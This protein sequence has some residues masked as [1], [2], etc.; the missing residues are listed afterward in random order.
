MED[1]VLGHKSISR[2]D[3]VENR[4]VIEPDK[5]VENAGQELLCLLDTLDRYT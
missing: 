4:T 2:P 3:S 5:V 1:A